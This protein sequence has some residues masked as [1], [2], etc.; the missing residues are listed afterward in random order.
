MLDQNGGAFHGELPRLTAACSSTISAGLTH[1]H[2]VV[3]GAH[4]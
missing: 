2:P 1:L 3:A 4:V